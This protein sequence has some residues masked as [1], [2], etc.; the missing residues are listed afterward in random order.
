MVKIDWKKQNKIARAS[1][2]AF[3]LEQDL[4]ENIRRLSIQDGL[5]TSAQI[6]KIIDLPYSP[7]KRPRLTISLTKEDYEKLG[8]KYQIKSSDTLEIKR[9]IVESLV[10][11]FSE[12]KIN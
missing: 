7:P 1:Q 11:Y 4:A 8:E 2:I 12:E 5:S 3:E 10:D 6:R 9:R